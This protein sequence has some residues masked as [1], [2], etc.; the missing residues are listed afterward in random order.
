MSFNENHPERRPDEVFLTNARDW[1]WDSIPFL[2]KR[3]GNVAHRRD[4]STIPPSE[5]AFPVFV[6][7]KEYEEKGTS[8]K[9]TLP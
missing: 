5:G 4:G 1:E 8:K 9:H 7:Q 3:R 2:S 6:K